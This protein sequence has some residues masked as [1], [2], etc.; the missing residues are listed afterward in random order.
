MTKTIALAAVI[1]FAQQVAR[2]ETAFE[3]ASVTP[4][5]PGTAAPPYEHAGVAPFVLPGGRFEARA[6]TVKFLLEWA[7]GV[8]P[9]Q[10]FGGPAW[11]GTDR[12]DIVAKAE[13]NATEAQMKLMA[14]ALLADR[15]QLTLHHETREVT[16]YVISPGKNAPRVTRSTEGEI[17]AMRFEPVAGADGKQTGFRVK[18]TR[19][20]VAQLSDAFARQLGGVIVDKTGLEGEYDFNFD[21]APDEHNPNPMD[22]TVLLRALREQIG[23]A[24]KSQKEP[25]DTVVIESVEKVA[26]GN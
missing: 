13:G 16:A 18:L 6:T 15:F 19:Y 11:L 8:Q 1:F 4:C 20:T 5:Q 12:Y 21:M 10:H 3:V 22:A 24:V 14:Q 17:H 2:S 9:S 7:Y 25:V 26:A 23:L